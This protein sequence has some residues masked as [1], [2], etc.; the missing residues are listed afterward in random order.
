MRN[1]DWHTMNNDPEVI[2]CKIYPLGGRVVVELTPVKSRYFKIGE[3]VSVE[4]GY[5]TLGSQRVY[6]QNVHIDGKILDIWTKQPEV[7]V[8]VI[9]L[10]EVKYDWNKNGTSSV[11][12]FDREHNRSNPEDLKISIESK[13]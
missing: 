1:P 12:F 3:D 7:V 9:S 13:A 10:Q 2:S 4:A 5:H 6:T 11:E 8:V